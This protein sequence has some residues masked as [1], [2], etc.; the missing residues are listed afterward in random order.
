VAASAEHGSE[1]LRL[2]PLQLHRDALQEKVRHRLVR[3]LGSG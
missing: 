2:S 3:S 1:L